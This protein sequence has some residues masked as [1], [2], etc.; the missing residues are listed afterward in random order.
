MDLRKE[1]D[2]HWEK[3]GLGLSVAMLAG[4]GVNLYCVRG[5]EPEVADIQSMKAAVQQ[6][7]ATN[8]PPALKAP[9]AF[10]HAVAPWAEVAAPA[11]A[12]DWAMYYKTEVVEVPDP[13]THEDEPE[14]KLED[15]LLPAT[16]AAAV[17]S[18]FHASVAWDLPRGA[19]G[20]TGFRVE[21]RVAASGPRG[22]GAAT[23]F[24]ECAS[25]PAEAR[26]LQDADV[27]PDTTYEY[28]VITLGKAA[29]V[30]G[31][32]AQA[33]TPNDLRIEFV[34]GS[35]AT[36]LVRLRLLTA[37]GKPGVSRT[38]QV[39]V[40]Q[41]VGTRVDQYVDGKRASLDF[42]TGLVVETIGTCEVPLPRSV[43]RT[44]T[45]TVPQLTLAGP[46][47]EKVLLL[48]VDPHGV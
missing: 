44:G 46:S 25:L 10:G 40:G 37:D 38:F 26:E 48:P 15:V 2:A 32:P 5:E 36:A 4:V 34:G 35:G 11:P 19:R 7:L 6:A 22:A 9:T 14:V 30:G 16:A 41:A 45:R 33:R 43:R 27:R 20:V 12:S 28:Q 31:T 24:T 39:G 21:R 8:R 18:P 17:Q 29:A 42:R 13:N 47:G 1:W 23:A 3:L